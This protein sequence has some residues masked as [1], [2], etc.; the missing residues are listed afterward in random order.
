MVQSLPHPPAGPRHGHL[1]RPQ[2]C[3]ARP[4]GAADRHPG[5]REALVRQAHPRG[6][7]AGLLQNAADMRE[8]QQ[9]KNGSKGAQRPDSAARRLGGGLGPARTGRRV[10]SGASV[11]LALHQCSAR[12]RLCREQPIQAGWAAWRGARQAPRHLGRPSAGRVG[13]GCGGSGGDGSERGGGPSRAQALTRMWAHV[14]TRTHTHTHSYPSGTPGTSKDLA[15]P[16]GPGPHGLQ[17]LAGLS[18]WGPG[19]VVERSGGQRGNT[20]T[21]LERV[22][23]T[24]WDTPPNPC[25][26]QTGRGLGDMG[27]SEGKNDKRRFVKIPSQITDKIAK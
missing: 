22:P 10:P 14:G 19:A 11:F 17:L 9:V 12:P 24:P 13:P 4:Q 1:Q 15:E 18:Q 23:Q 21:P 3:R 5:A 27:G 26:L 16:L 20:G 7:R 6:L 25:S 2:G 8:H